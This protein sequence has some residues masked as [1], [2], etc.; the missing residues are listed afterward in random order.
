[1]TLEKTCRSELAQ[2]VADHILD[3]VHRDMLAAVMDGDS[4]TNEF[5]EYDRS[6]GPGLY[7][8]LLVFGIHGANTVVELL[9]YERR[10]FKTSARLYSLLT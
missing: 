7:D 2:S 6:T 1:M 10:L 4:V 5:G 8:L 9:F 3:D